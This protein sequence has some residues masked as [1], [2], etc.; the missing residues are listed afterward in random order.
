LAAQVDILERQASALIS[1]RQPHED[2]F[3][4]CFD[5]SW[6]LRSHGL[7]GDTI[8]AQTGQRKRADL[9]DST[10]TDSGNVLVAGT[11]GGM[12]PANARWFGLSASGVSEE[13]E[14][15]LDEAATVVWENI[16]QAN[17]DATAPEM[18][19]DVIGCGWGALYIDTDRDAGG[20]SFEW[21]PVGGVYVASTK[22]GGMVD[23][24]L[25]CYELTAEQCVNA[26]GENMVS[27]TV[28]KLAQDKP[29]ERVKLRWL[30]YPR[31]D[32]RPGNRFANNLP[33]ASCTWEADSKKLVR[34]SGY[35]EMPVIVPRWSLLPNSSYA[36]GPVFDALPDIKQ[37][38]DLVFSENAAVDLA[39][40]GMWIAEDDGVLNPRTVKVGPRKVIVANS[41]DSMKSLLTGADFNVSFT[42]KADLQGAIRRTLMADQLQPPQDPR[43]TATEWL[44]R[45]A[46]LRQLLGPRFGRLQAEWLQPM[47]ARC[48]GLALREGALG[49]MPDELR[50][51]AASIQYI[52]PLARSQKLEEVNAMDRYEADLMASAQLRPDALDLYDW[53]AAKREKAKLLGVPL[54]LLRDARDV[55]QMRDERNR[56]VQ[57]QQ[58]QAMQ[59]QAATAMIDATAQRMA[60]A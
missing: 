12:T 49:Q 27:E 29:D 46:L 25:R 42:K 55:A 20:M 35:H 19:T 23:V 4:E 14:A 51:R 33:I 1:A 39:V 47:V 60:R 59:Q 50:T 2:T 26:F 58:Q 24:V 17:F 43:M 38:N 31:R 11:I 32:R 5:H 36:I 48:F 18:M 44:G 15:W 13:A 41:V 22:P 8:D 54:K 53:D 45:M 7:A 40:S 10:S 56:A 16:H 6:P 57:A 9:L 34:E 52:S 37:L 30:I 28:R 21:W 3:K